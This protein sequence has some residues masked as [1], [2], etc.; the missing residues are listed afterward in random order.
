MSP[1]HCEL[2]LFDFV[3]S[4]VKKHVEINNTTSNLNDVRK[5]LNDGI[6]QVTPEMWYNFITLALNEEEDVGL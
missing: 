5:L 1:Y 4:V 3:W 2:H 6:Q